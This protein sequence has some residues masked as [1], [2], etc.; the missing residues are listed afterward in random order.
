LSSNPEVYRPT[1]A[2]GAGRRHGS[3]PLPDS[4]LDLLACLFEGGGRDLH[5]QIGLHDSLSESVGQPAR[6]R[7]CSRNRSSQ[8]PVE[9]ARQLAREITRGLS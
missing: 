1:F 7:N 6:S 9:E 2:L 5:E 8:P 3:F 4:L